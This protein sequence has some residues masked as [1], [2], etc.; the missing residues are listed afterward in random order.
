ME[1]LSELEDIKVFHTVYF[2]NQTCRIAG[3]IAGIAE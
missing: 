2:G 1:R 3:I